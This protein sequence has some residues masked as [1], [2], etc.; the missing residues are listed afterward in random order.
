ML[1]SK[2]ITTE[3]ERAQV[4][5]RKLGTQIRD[6]GRDLENQRSKVKFVERD[7]ARAKDELKHQEQEFERV[8]RIVKDTES[9]LKEVTDKDNEYRKNIS[10]LEVQLKQVVD[11]LKSDRRR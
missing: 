7:L 8:S 1:N 5:H 11:G 4:E 3:L 6:Y 2:V 10:R 9:R